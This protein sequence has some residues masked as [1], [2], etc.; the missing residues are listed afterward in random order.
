MSLLQSMGVS[1]VVIKPLTLPGVGNVAIMYLLYKMATPLRYAITLGGTQFAV[2]QLTRAGYIKP[3]PEKDRM[4]NL[5]KDKMGDMKE[6]MT[7]GIRDKREQFKEKVTEMKGDMR[8]RVSDMKGDVS[9]RM[10]S[11]ARN[12]KGSVK[13]KITKQIKSL[14]DNYARKR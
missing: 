6:D 1:A 10:R 12:I 5:V 13:G 8:N 3:P 4:R 9:D 2:R 14:Q 11:K 7:H